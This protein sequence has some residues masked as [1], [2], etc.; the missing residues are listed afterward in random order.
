MRIVALIDLPANTFG[1]TGVATTVII[2]YK[3][4]N[5]EKEILSDD[6]QV[7]VKEI[8]HVGYTVK[9]K[10]KVIDMPPDYLIDEETYEIVCDDYGNKCILSDFPE[11]VSEFGEWLSNNKHRYKSI[12]EAFAGDS[13]QEWSE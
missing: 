4:K 5:N 7:F 11:L 9:E 6:Y 2:A 3:P 13:Y 1:Q 10:N 12:Y 8:E